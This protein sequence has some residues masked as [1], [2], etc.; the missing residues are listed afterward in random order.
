MQTL[1]QSPFTWLEFDKGGSIDPQQTGGG[2]HVNGEYCLLL[3]K[4]KIS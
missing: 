2:C 4:Q 3:V 1:G